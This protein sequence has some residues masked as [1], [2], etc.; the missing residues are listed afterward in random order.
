MRPIDPRPDVVVS[1]CDGIVVAAGRIQDTRLIQA[2]GLSYTLEEL[3]VDPALAD[4]HRNGVYVTVRLPSTAYHRF[5]APDDC[6]VDHVTYVAGDVWNVNPAA[7]QRIDQLYCRNERAIMRA[8]LCKS[9]EALTLVPVAAILVASIRLTF[10]DVLLNLK[11][12][13]PNDIPCRAAFAKGEELGHF[14]H[15]STIIVLATHLSIS[16]DIRVGSAVRMGCPLLT[17]SPQGSDAA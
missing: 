1:P 13:G 10:L 4:R 5:H 7:L 17:R 16:P 11:Y 6:E 14:H 12:A 15:G 2:K 9:G 8:R 3:L